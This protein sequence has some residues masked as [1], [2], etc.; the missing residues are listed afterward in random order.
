MGNYHKYG[1]PVCAAQPDGTKW[2]DA[3]ESGRLQGKILVDECRK[4][5]DRIDKN[6]DGVLQYVMLEGEAGHNDSLARSMAVIEE[7]TESGYMVEKL[8][9]EIANWNRDQ[10]ATKMQTFLATYGEEIEVILANNDD[11]AL[12][13]ADVLKEAGWKPGD[14][15]WPVILGIDGTSVG[16]DAVKKGEF[17]GTVLHDGEG[18]A[19]AM[20]ELA[21]ALVT[22]NELPE[23]YRLKDGKYIRL[24]YRAITADHL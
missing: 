21:Y 1:Y 2:A 16:L 11:M 22:E 20:L 23:E 7:I 9:D 4:H 10:A 14:A 19:H 5:F 13:A 15:E 3:Y 12:G 18:Q 24:P 8:A 6:K 17:L